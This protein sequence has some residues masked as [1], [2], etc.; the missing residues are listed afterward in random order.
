MKP[1]HKVKK[2]PVLSLV[3]LKRIFIA[4]L[5]EFGPIFL[6]ILSYDRYHIY[7]ATTILMLA[8]ILT[9]IVTFTVQKRLPYVALYMALLTILFGYLTVAHHQPKFIQIRDT[10]YDLVLALTLL[11]G[12]LT[13][14]LFLKLSFHSVVPMSKKAWEY[15]TY[16]WAAF[17]L[18]AAALNEYV[19]RTMDLHSW[20]EF[21]SFMILV[22]IVFGLIVLYFFYEHDGEL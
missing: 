9:T 11:I 6:F 4:G 20:F 8:T 5:L 7:K 16:S 13:Q 12:L 19:R 10:L 1:S 22:T 3:L 15:L 21:K 14:Q 2:L 18:I 17:L